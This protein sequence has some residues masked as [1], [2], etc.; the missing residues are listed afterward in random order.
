MNKASIVV[1][2]V[3]LA[4]GLFLSNA[5]SAK[6]MTSGD[7]EMTQD[8]KHVFSRMDAN[9]DGFIDKDEARTNPDLAAKFN[10]VDSNKDKRL[11]EGEFARFEVTEQDTRNMR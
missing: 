6:D 7:K 3:S 10:K 5:V 4:S 11:D 9:G 8:S 1:A 2:V